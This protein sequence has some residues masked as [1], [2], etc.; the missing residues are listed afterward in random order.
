MGLPTD[1]EAAL[2][3]VRGVADEPLSR[4]LVDHPH[5]MLRR[6]EDRYVLSSPEGEAAAAVA[7]LSGVAA[8]NEPEL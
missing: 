4:A 2:L 1:A 6:G 8:G 7:S 3:I 5:L